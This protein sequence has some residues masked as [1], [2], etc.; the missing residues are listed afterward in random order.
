MKTFLLNSGDDLPD[1][2]G[3]HRRTPSRP[4]VQSFRHPTCS[5]ARNSYEIYPSL[6]T[7]HWLIWNVVVFLYTPHKATTPRG[8]IMKQ[9]SADWDSGGVW[10]TPVPL[11]RPG[12]PASL[13]P[14]C[15]WESHTWSRGAFLL[16]VLH[17]GAAVKAW[18]GA[19]SWWS[20]AV[21]PHAP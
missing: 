15:S 2:T 1:T 6:S 17:G 16:S 9:W 19:E 10:G 8:R 7:Q 14:S 18:F 3:F 21:P 11:V 12:P 4:H 13:L 5:V 20:G